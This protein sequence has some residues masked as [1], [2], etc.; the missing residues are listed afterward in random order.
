MISNP[1]SSQSASANFNLNYVAKS[2]AAQDQLIIRVHGQGA[3]LI[4]GEEFGEWLTGVSGGWTE[5]QVSSPY[6]LSP[7]LTVYVNDGPEGYRLNFYD[8]E[9]GLAML[10]GDGDFR[11]YIISPQQYEQIYG[12]WGSRSYFIPEVVVRAL[13][14]GKKTNRQ[15][16]QDIP[17]EKDYRVIEIGKELYYLYQK[18]G[19]YYCERLSKH[20][21]DLNLVK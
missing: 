4:T 18:G 3:S 2:S 5:K 10:S 12:L 21:P 20:L 7:G 6:E 16:V 13:L 17:D 14:E 8:S 1:E 19:N 11:Y 15:S 9:K